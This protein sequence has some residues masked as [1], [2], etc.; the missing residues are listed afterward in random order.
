MKEYLGYKTGDHYET[1]FDSLCVN[2]A[3]DPKPVIMVNNANT[4][5]NVSG[6]LRVRNLKFSGI[7]ALAKPINSTKFDPSVFPQ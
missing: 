5:F 4:Y 7:N 1:S 2:L 6:S 3:R